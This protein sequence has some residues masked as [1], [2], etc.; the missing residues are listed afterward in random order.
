[1]LIVIRHC[2]SEWKQNECLWKLD[3]EFNRKFKQRKKSGTI[4]LMWTINAHGTNQTKNKSHSYYV[5]RVKPHTFIA[6]GKIRT[7]AVFQRDVVCNLTTQNNMGYLLALNLYYYMKRNI[8]T[9]NVGFTSKPHHMHH[10]KNRS[11]VKQ[12]HLWDSRNLR[13]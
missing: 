11:N 1:M 6:F 13:Y 3:S 12:C 5:A 2:R 10:I 8:W 7:G 4:P 9:Y